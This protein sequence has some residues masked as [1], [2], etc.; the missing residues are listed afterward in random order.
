MH[1]LYPAESIPF[2]VAPPGAVLTET[3]CDLKGNIYL[4]QSTSLPLSSPP[5]GLSGIPVSRLSMDSK[6]V[7]AYAVP[8]L[9]GYRG[10]VRS[11]FDVSADGRVYSLLE[12]L[13]ASAAKDQAP[14]AFI[15]KYKD[16]GTLDTYFKLGNAPEGRIYPHR[17]AMFRGGNALITGTV[18]TE[19]RLRPF[20]AVLDPAGS[21]VTYV[22]VQPPAPKAEGRAAP[23]RSAEGEA[24]R[25]GSTSEAGSQE[26][27]HSEADAAVILSSSSFIVSASDG[28]VYLLQGVGEARVHVISPAGEIVRDFEVSPPAPGL[29][30]TNMGMAGDDRVFIS[31]GRVLG[32]SAGSANNGGPHDLISLISPQTGEVSAVYRLTGE[33]DAFEVP[34]CAA[35]SYNFLFVGATPDQKH[36]QVTRFLP[37]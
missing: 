20:T 4:V 9:D 28:N 7:V 12:G 10:V 29:T 6:S 5:T 31:F 14:S 26:A 36:L 33:E 37:R 23:A 18:V 34:G 13:D 22:K 16:D 17:F 25:A 30:A 32:A 27:E 19:G 8:S 15:A 24:S 3:K 11:D 1:D 35:S 21:F 2:P